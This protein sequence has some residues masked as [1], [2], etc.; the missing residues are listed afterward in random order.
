MKTPKIHPVKINFEIPI[1]PTY[2]LPRFVYLYIIED[3]KIHFIDSG[4]ASGMVQIEEFLKSINHDITS[5]ENIF[6]THSHPDHI[7]AA[8][9]I[10]QKSNCS[11]YALKNELDWITNTEL[12]FQQR[13]VPGFRNLVSGSVTVDHILED[14]Q[15]I[16]IEND[17]AL[18]IISTP[19]HS[20]G[21]ASF[22]F[23]EQ[24]T[25]FCGDAILLPGE[26]P[27]FENINDYFDSLEKIKK[28]K[29][30]VLYSSWDVPRY[31]NEIPEIID[32]SKA[33]I[34]KIQKASVKISKNFENTSSIEF[35]KSVLSELG[36]NDSLANPLLTKSFN[37]CLLD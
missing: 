32:K 27:I 1:S 36:L 30:E 25:L 33:Y 3:D 18:K 16:Q 37:A 24:K 11:V 12:Q 10:Q 17:I 19:G 26:L 35:C 14:E 6:L 8:R 23:E 9:F 21:S 5:V 13:P 4:I 22:Y 28:L 34:F 31:R 29:P 2:K 7:G 20:A 15:L